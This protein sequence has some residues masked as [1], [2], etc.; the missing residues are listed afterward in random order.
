MYTYVQ[1]KVPSYTHVPLI[2]LSVENADKEHSKW[3]LQTGVL[4]LPIKCRL[5]LCVIYTTPY[6]FVPAKNT[7]Y[8]MLLSILFSRPCNTQFRHLVILKADLWSSP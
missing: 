5:L 8:S 3:K 2:L 1:Y 7:L 6:V 4:S